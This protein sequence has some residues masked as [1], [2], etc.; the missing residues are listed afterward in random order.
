MKPAKWCMFVAHDNSMPSKA[1]HCGAHLFPEYRKIRR[2]VCHHDTG[3]ETEIA[4]VFLYI[5][6]LKPR[7]VPRSSPKEGYG[8]RQYVNVRRS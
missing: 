2:R 3:E 7:S 5:V 4:Q 1:T 6:D 8:F